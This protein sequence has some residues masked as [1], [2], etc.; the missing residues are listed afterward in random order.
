MTEAT[1]IDEVELLDEQGHAIGVADRAS[2]QG[3]GAS[4]HLAFSCHVLNDRGEVLITRRALSKPE[5]PGV[6]SNA[7]CGHPQAAEPLLAAVRR[8]A[9]YA[10]G[11]ELEHLELAQPLL[12]YR[13]TSLS[14]VVETETCPV[15][16]ASTSQ[17]VTVHPA[18]VMD[19]AWIDPVDLGRSIR[20]TPAAFSPWLVLQAEHLP[21]LGGAERVDA[22][23]QPRLDTADLETDARERVLK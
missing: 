18:E 23:R 21:L 7:F 19:H 11:L 22:R 8:S 6:W 13:A 2:V 1:M 3:P 16:I 9:N 15:Y 20:L 4:Q 14:G 17:R 5:W 12:R 10:L